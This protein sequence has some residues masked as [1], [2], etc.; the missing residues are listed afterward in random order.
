MKDQQVLYKFD[1][2]EER[3]YEVHNEGNGVYLL[4]GKKIERLVQMTSFSSDDAL[5]RFA[6]QLRNMGIV[7]ALRKAGA[8]DGDTVR[9]LDFEFDFND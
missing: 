8:K 7:D 9:I 4:T 1:G 6:L 2:K 3:G 5:K